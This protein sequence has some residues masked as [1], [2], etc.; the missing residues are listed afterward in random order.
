MNL[1]HI[2]YINKTGKIKKDTREAFFIESIY[3]RCSHVFICTCKCTYVHEYPVL[4]V[5]EKRRKSLPLRC[6]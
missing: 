4:I 1:E 3:A 2:L 6:T 5:P